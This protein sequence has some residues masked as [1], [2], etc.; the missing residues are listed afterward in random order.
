M[1]KL[2]GKPVS[3]SRSSSLWSVVLAMAAALLLVGFAPAAVRADVS[4]YGNASDNTPAPCPIGT[5]ACPSSDPFY[6]APA[7]LGSLANG[8]LVGVRP[9]TISEPGLSPKAASTI[10]YRSSDSFGA[11]VLDTATVL[12]PSAAYSG[13]GARPLV[14]YQ[15]P[16]DSLGAQCAPSYAIA[17]PNTNG[18][19]DGGS[20]EIS[21]LLSQ[22]YVVVA[23][24]FDGPAQ[25]FIAGQQ[26]G[27]A[28]LDGIRAAKTLPGAGLSHATPAAMEG[29]SGGGHGTS[30]AAELAGSYAPDLHIVGAAEG[31]TPADI[32][33]NAKYA[34]GTAFFGLV[35]LASEGL[36]R[37]FPGAGF[38][39]DLNAMGTAT[40][41]S[42]SP[43]CVGTAVSSY[44]FGNL[45]QYTKQPD[46]V[47]SPSLQALFAHEKLGQAAPSFPL[48][49]Y[50]VYNDE[51]VPFTPDLALSAFYCSK[52][53]PVQ[54]VPLAGDHISGDPS[55]FPLVLSFL[56]GRFSGATFADNCSTVAS[57]S[58]LP[59]V[60]PVA[61]SG[62][63][64]SG[65]STPGTGSSS[66]G[67]SSS[68]AANTAS[69]TA[70][71]RA[72]SLRLIR[73]CVGAGKLRVSVT[74]RGVRVRSVAWSLGLHVAARAKRAPFRRIVARGPLART[75]SSRL[76]A[77]VMLVGGRKIVL[78]RSLPRC[79]IPARKR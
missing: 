4:T 26:E 50:H 48:F 6:A 27:H 22:G 66:T 41:K 15:F 51:L 34:N 32:L 39:G 31:G 18:N 9:A 30:W 8:T 76:R 59:Q 35:L 55:G 63:G 71:A 47:D 10:S 17:H 61:L 21:S 58:G 60:P 25:Q 38:A 5:V 14:S 57:L 70:A 53:T 75:R 64:Q 74:G 12:L 72:R 1:S 19:V 7:N 42:L 65:S 40:F 36:T 11:P 24:D 43:Q 23:P 77:V 46:L 73:R 45:D 78:V 13:P 52:S 54:F 62:S 37:A 20:N 28:V 79:G 67:S 44:P 29:Y 49:R 33:V 56:Q 69:K 68:A 2:E 16:I 3:L